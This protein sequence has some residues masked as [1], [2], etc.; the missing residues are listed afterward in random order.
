[1][2]ALQQ[3]MAGGGG[4]ATGSLTGSGTMVIP[5]ASTLVTFVGRGGVGTSTPIPQFRWV[6]Q[7]RVAISPTNG[8]PYGGVPQ[9]SGTP[10]SL[11]QT[12]TITQNFNDGEH[13]NDGF[14]TYYYAYSS[15]TYVSQ[16]N[17]AYISPYATYTVGPSTTATL[18]GTTRTWVGGT[19]AVAGT[20]STQTIT[21]G[22]AGQ[23]VSYAVGSGGSLTYEY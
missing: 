10:T 19:G 2:S 20:Q 21:S 17:P 15:I 3:M 7:S 16:N 6:E 5:G 18:N 11:G 14:Y 1:M 12:Q 4:K 13:S 9:A 8:S 22:G 23:S